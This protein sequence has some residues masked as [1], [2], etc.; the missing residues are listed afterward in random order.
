MRQLLRDCRIL[1]DADAT[2]AVAAWLTREQAR[3]H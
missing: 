2:Q 3:F 1:L